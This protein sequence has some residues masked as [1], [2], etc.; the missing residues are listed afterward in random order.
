MKLCMRILTMRTNLRINFHLVRVTVCVDSWISNALCA[1]SWCTH[2]TWSTFGKVKNLF[3]FIMKFKRITSGQLTWRQHVAL[4]Y[5]CT[6]DRSR[7]PNNASRNLTGNIVYVIYTKINTHPLDD[8]VFLCESRK[9]KQKQNEQFHS[10]SPFIIHFN[11]LMQ[12]QSIGISVLWKAINESKLVEKFFFIGIMKFV[13]F[14]NR[15][16]SVLVC[17]C[18]RLFAIRCVWKSKWI[19]NSR[20]MKI[21]LYTAPNGADAVE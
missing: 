14:I 9:I 1:I 17:V 15:H 2:Y 18:E 3:A 20:T 7:P 21:G 4:K 12:T 10:I 6:I 11:R 16:S 19:E 13:W 5:T 8:F